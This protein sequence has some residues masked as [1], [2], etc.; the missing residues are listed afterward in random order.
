MNLWTPTKSNSF[1]GV[2]SK[3]GEAI[4]TARRLMKQKA[5][6]LSDIADNDLLG[7]ND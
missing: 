4:I 1:D 7:K 3:N 5:L 6:S 2:S